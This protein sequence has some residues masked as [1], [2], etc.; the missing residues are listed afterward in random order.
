MKAEIKIHTIENKDN[1]AMNLKLTL[2]KYGQLIQEAENI[3]EKLCRGWREI[4]N[5]T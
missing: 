1:K 5:N 4:R 2:G 3:F